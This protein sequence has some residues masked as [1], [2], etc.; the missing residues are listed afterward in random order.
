MGK[1]NF[2]VQCAN[3]F[4]AVVVNL[5]MVAVASGH[6]GGLDG[7]GGHNNRKN[8]GYHCH[9]EPCLSAHAKQRQALEEAVVE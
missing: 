5:L 8:G 3:A 1:N 2:G 7:N 9:R 4:T 6:G